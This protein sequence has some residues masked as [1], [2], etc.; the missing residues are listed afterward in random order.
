MR[1]LNN[2]E[3][4]RLLVRQEYAAAFDRWLAVTTTAHGDADSDSSDD[5]EPIVPPKFPDS[6]DVQGAAEGRATQVTP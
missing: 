3:L 5:F 4:L 1:Q 6:G 2:D